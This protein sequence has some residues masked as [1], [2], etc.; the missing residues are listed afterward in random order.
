MS[1]IFEL[2]MF[3]LPNVINMLLIQQLKILLHVYLTS[4]YAQIQH[5]GQHRAQLPAMFDF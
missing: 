1:L 5:G 4:N 2:M 3:Q